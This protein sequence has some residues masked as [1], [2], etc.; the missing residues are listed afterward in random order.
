MNVPNTETLQTIYSALAD[1]TSKMIYRHRLLYSLLG[2]K[3]EITSLAN[4][5]LPA[6]VSLKAAKICYYGAGEGGWWFIQW[7]RDVPF[8]IDQYK[9]GTLAD[10]PVISL[11]DFLKLP[12]FAE[13][14]IVIAVSKPNIRDEIVAELEN[15]GLHYVLGYP[16]LQYFDLPELDLRNEYFADVGALDGDTTKYFLEHFKGGHAYVFEP[17]PKQF[18]ITKE[19]LRGYPQVELFP[20]GIY[21]ENTT[22]RFDSQEDSVGSSR[23]SN[24]GCIKVDVRKLDDLLGDRKV[25]CLKMDIEG[26]ELA[27]LRGAERIIREQRPKLAICIYHKPEDIWEI[28]GFILKCCPDYRLYIRQYSL[29]DIETVL[30][31]I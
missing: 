28:P 30:Y 24:S 14:L 6:D 27:A 4:D 21:D 22:L 7:N 31:A 26:S 16:G 25:T 3:A 29:F 18:E 20:Y 13:Y 17:N 10:I 12:D 8:V 5:I 19:C 9:T 2:E 11:G 15:H 23:L 1:D